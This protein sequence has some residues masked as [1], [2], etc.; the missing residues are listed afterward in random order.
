MDTRPLGTRCPFYIIAFLT[1]IGTA[2]PASG[3]TRVAR[4]LSGVSPD[5]RD[6][7]RL[8][9]GRIVKEGGVQTLRRRDAVAHTRDACAPRDKGTL[10]SPMQRATCA[11][12]VQRRCKVQPPAGLRGR[13][14]RK[15]WGKLNLRTAVGGK[16]LREDVEVTGSCEHP[17]A[18]LVVRGA[19]GAT[20]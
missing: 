4:V 15:N 9:G 18:H 6:G 19:D 12:L 17:D 11:N 13:M 2:R 16:I 10:R 8:S 20:A 5:I 7:C 1:Y 3:S 14:S